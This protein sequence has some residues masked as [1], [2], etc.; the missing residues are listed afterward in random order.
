MRSIACYERIR[1]DV[2]K[3]GLV[4]SKRWIKR[5]RRAEPAHQP[6]QS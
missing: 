6:T 5:Y 1:A 3:L 2:L 4:A